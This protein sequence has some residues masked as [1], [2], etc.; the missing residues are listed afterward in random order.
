MMYSI[1]MKS[2][3]MVRLLEDVAIDTVTVSDDVY[4]HGYFLYENE[5]FVMT[6]KKKEHIHNS[7][8]RA[9]VM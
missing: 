7:D 5:F 6:R 9:L 2:S 4:M 3:T 1:L 8:L